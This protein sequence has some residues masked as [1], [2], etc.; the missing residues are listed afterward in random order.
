MLNWVAF[1]RLEKDCQGYL[2]KSGVVEK[3][4]KKEM[5]LYTVI[6]L[7]NFVVN[8]G[9]GIFSFGVSTSFMS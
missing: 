5:S 1:D 2:E 7:I 6:T 8:R 4:R 3:E 9:R